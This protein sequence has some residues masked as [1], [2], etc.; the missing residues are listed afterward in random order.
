MSLDGLMMKMKRMRKKVVF[1]SLVVPEGWIAKM[2]K[3]RKRVE[4]MDVARAVRVGG[5]STGGEHCRDEIGGE[6]ERRRD[7]GEE[8]VEL[9]V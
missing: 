6:M 7:G 8:E 4:E 1:A 2:T 5:G 9:F 3:F